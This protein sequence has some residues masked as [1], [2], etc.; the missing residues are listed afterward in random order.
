VYCP[1]VFFGGKNYFDFWCQENGLFIRSVDKNA[2]LAFIFLYK[3]IC[4]CMHIIIVLCLV[5]YF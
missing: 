4:I 1:Y 2:L 3:C 5:R